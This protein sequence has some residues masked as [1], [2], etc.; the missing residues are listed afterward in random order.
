M[1]LKTENS[2]EEKL[3]LLSDAA[4]YDVACT[5]SGANRKGGDIWGIA[6]LQVS[7]I[8]F[9]QMEDVFPCLRF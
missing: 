2:L 7:V 3:I 6:L 1:L 5:S 4:K 9:P 8:L